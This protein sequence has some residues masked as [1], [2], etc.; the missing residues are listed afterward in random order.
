MIRTAYLYL[1]SLVGLA[2]IVIGCVS[3]V[4]LG[5]KTFV[6][7]QADQVIVYPWPRQE[8][9]PAGTEAGA[10]EQEQIDYQIYREQEQTAQRQRSAASALAMIIVGLP[11]SRIIRNKRG[12]FP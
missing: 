8:L 9:E 4:N 1:A 10:I 5:L 6:F 7:K 2:L 3:L 11:L 12:R